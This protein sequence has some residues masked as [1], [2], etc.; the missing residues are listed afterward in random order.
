MLKNWSKFLESHFELENQRRD[1]QD[2]V[3]LLK[4]FIRESDYGLPQQF[5]RS[6]SYTAQSNK[7][8]LDPQKDFDIVNNWMSEHGWPFDKA[9]KFAKNYRGEFSSGLLT[10]NVSGCDPID[11]YLYKVTDG[12]FLLQGYEWTFFGD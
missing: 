11:Y 10:S 4:G 8:D 7:G 1:Y 9:K 6:Y 12:E 5:Y 2:F 3:D